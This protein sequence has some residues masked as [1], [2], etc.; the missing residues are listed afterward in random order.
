MLCCG[1]CC[2]RRFCCADDVDAA[3]VMLVTQLQ[4]LASRI[5]RV[6]VESMILLS[7]IN[8]KRFN[9][10][11]CMNKIEFILFRPLSAFWKFWEEVL[12]AT[13]KGGLGD[14]LQN[15]GP[16]DLERNEM[17]DPHEIRAIPPYLTE[18]SKKQNK[19]TSHSQQTE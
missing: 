19:R 13:N 11:R 7:Y 9:S 6:A 5:P 16:V 10:M 2:G 17:G 14:N 3:A 18:Q 4:L 1:R 12:S 8:F 15:T